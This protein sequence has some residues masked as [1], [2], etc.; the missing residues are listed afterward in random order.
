MLYQE[1]NPHGGDIY[2]RE[3]ALDLSVNTNPLG[4]P[5][6][7]RR[8]VAEAADRLYRYPDPYCR[9]LV[10][11]LAAYE[12]VPEDFILCGNGAAELLFSFCAA[13]RPKR[14]LELAPTFS[15]YARALRSV[16]CTV[17]RH[18]LRPERDF[19]LE[20]DLLT[21]LQATGCEVLFLCNPNNP[22]GRLIEPSLL[23]RI[24]A[25]C[26]E[27]GIRLFLDECFLE[28]SDAGREASP[29]G[30]L[31][32]WPGLF[33]LKALTKSY[34]MAGLRLGYGLSG[35]SALLSAMSACVQP[36]NV[37]I[38]AQEAGLAALREET[39]FPERA[40]ALIRAERPRMEKHLRDLG[41]HVCPSEANYL[42]LHSARPLHALL[43]A[44]GILTRDC[45]G[46]PGLKPG[47]LRIAVRTPEE[48]RRFLE[49][50]EA[51]PGPERQ[52]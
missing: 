5:E 47:W 49:T 11:A 1:K 7:V 35:D 39:E 20:E 43:L 46:C 21:V 26:R 14:A 44:E 3:V 50:L 40:R 22:T 31:A 42:L 13:L 4:T 41:I 8:A 6:G 2:G 38:P 45:K 52:G 12:G 51:L 25:V 10:G 37:S 32:E 30:L 28:L 48:N 34:G 19:A 17:E 9:E 23:H 29:K 24:A 27:R 16:G 15:E 18:A 33:I 36:W